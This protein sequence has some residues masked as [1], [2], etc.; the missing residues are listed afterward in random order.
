MWHGRQSISRGRAFAVALVMDGNSQP[1]CPLREFFTD[2]PPQL[3]IV[4]SLLLLHNRFTQNDHTFLRGRNP[5]AGGLSPCSS[6]P[7]EAAGFFPRPARARRICLPRGLTPTP[8]GRWPPFFTERRLHE[9]LAHLTTRRQDFPR[10][11]DPGEGKQKAA[12]FLWLDYGYCP[13]GIFLFFMECSL[14]IPA[15][16]QGKKNQA[17]SFEGNIK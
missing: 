1:R 9:L 15:H 10:T 16:T 8:A 7:R 3:F 17:L 12:R 2:S 5:G 14:F 13:L 6:A 11:S 4:S